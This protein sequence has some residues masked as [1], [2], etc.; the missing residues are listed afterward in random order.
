LGFD[1]QQFR[2]PIKKR[3]GGGKKKSKQD[4]SAEIETAE[5]I[6]EWLLDILEKNTVVNQMDKMTI[7]ALGDRFQTL[8]KLDWKK[9]LK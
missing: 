9:K 5:D 3:S 1:P 8:T 4:G 7:A 2:N 6:V